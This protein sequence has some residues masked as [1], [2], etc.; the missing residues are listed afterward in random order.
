[1]S[2]D[3]WR[4]FAVSLGEAVTFFQFAMLDHELGASQRMNG[5]VNDRF[6]D[7]CGNLTTTTAS[8]HTTPA[9]GRRQA[10]IAFVL[11]ESSS[12]MATAFRRVRFLAKAR[13]KRANAG[14]A[15]ALYLCGQQRAQQL[16]RLHLNGDSAMTRTL[17]EI[18]GDP[19]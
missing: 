16:C 19:K 10:C 15:R 8:P 1:M 5:T 11:D 2:Q 3:A 9:Q 14:Y 17:R 4:P 6:S 18:Q 13:E 7:E 12:I